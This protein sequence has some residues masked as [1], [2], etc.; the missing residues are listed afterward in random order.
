M[1]SGNFGLDGLQSFV[2]GLHLEELVNGHCRY[3]VN[4]DGDDANAAMSALGHLGLAQQRAGWLG[5]G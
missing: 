4:R 2:D 1:R 5:G 3:I